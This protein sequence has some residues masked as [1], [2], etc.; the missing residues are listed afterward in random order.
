MKILLIICLCL[1]GSTFLAANPARLAVGAVKEGAEFV[2]GRVVAGQT[3]KVAA[4]SCIHSSI[5]AAT[6]ETDLVRRIGEQVTPGRIVA[7]GAATGAVVIADGYGDALEIS[8]EKA[9]ESFA[10][11]TAT[12]LRPLVWLTAVLF[13]VILFPFLLPCILRS[14]KIIK[15]GNPS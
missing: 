5:R 13:C 12:M 8:A 3:G 10:S 7:T 14:L 4:E 9:P 11:T 15:K 6:H 2:T 1:I